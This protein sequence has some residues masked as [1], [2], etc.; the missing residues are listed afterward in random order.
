MTD[1]KAILFDLDDTLIAAYGDPQAAWGEVAA[2]FS[3][4]LHPAR[5][6]LVEA[7]LA[8]GAIYWADAE[9]SRRGRLDIL[10][11]R[12]K[13]VAQAFNQLGL[14]TRAVL[15]D[16]LIDRM[17]V[18]FGQY[19][20]ERMHLF[21]DTHAVLD[22]VRERGVRLGLVTNGAGVAQRAKLDRFDLARRFD[23]I[24]I[25]GEAGYGK[26]DR[27]AF[28]ATL[29]ALDARPDEAW[30]VGDNFDADIVEAHRLGLTTHWVNPTAR[31]LPGQTQPSRTVSRLS[32]ILTAL[33]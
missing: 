1:P 10:D 20:D 7:I 17:V 5:D 15:Q 16:D 33:R 9:R 18:R 23:H 11:A 14:P 13:I 22:E 31:R 21:E 19:R 12:R 30:M 2:E 28:T 29:T 26:P 32:E 3:D 25:E 27:R 6:E 8:T 24:Q 4:E